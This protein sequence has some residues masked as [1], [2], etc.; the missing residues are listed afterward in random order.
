M[1]LAEDSKED[2]MNIALISIGADLY[3][4]FIINSGF[5]DFARLTTFVSFYPGDLILAKPKIGKSYTIVVL[6][7]L[8]EFL[9]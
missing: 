7:N 8:D 3:T 9:R 2:Q 4:R 1:R 6:I 5:G